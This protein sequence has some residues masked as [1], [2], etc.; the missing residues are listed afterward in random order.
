MLKDIQNL[1]QQNNAVRRIIIKCIEVL[2]KRGLLK[3]LPF[4]V[5]IAIYHYNTVPSPLEGYQPKSRTSLQWGLYSLL[6]LPPLKIY[7]YV[8]VL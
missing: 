6:M 4:V 7:T 2:S 1:L 8:A 3:E 5:F